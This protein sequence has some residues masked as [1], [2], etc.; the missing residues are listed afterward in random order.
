MAF[1]I[2][3]SKHSTFRGFSDTVPGPKQVETM[4]TMSAKAVVGQGI[5]VTDESQEQR[6]TFSKQTYLESYIVL[7]LCADNELASSAAYHLYVKVRILEFRVSAEMAPEVRFPTQKVG[8]SSS[9]L[10]W[11]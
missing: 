6:P 4:T 8:D 7:S 3:H 1:P 10:S 2:V 11:L 9:S 5:N